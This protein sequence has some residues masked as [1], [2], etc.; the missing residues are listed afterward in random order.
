[1]TDRRL[2]PANAR[3]A[4]TALKGLVQDVT[5]TDGT[6]MTVTVPVA[7]LLAAPGGARDR[8]LLYGE[9]VTVFEVTDGMAFV[10]AGKDGYVGYVLQDMLG[11]SVVPTH[12]VS[13][14]ATHLYPQPELKC[15]EVM[16]LGFGARLRIVS[17]SGAYF[18]TDAG[19]FVPKPHIRPLNAPLA[20]FVTVAQM[21]FG[22]PYLWGGNSN[23][24]ID[25]S[26]L[27]QAG[28]IAC[29]VD[30]PGDSDLQMAALGRDVAGGDVKRGDLFFFKGH[31]AI[32]VDAET[33]IHA[34]AH[35]MAVAYEPLAEAISRIETQGEGPVLAQKRL[36]HGV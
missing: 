6:A 30:C 35:H 18:E 13:V 25:C 27:V 19:Y 2:T 24:G 3:V 8:Q 10:Q 29:G 36:D 21:H 1:M 20:D 22:V 9:A 5:F 4:A 16:G 17:A 34:N 31:V 15:P 33:L 23:T 11:E 7:D 32:A 12:R 28:L 14:L 26:G